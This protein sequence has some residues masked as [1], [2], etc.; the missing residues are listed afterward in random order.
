MDGLSAW[1]RTPLFVG[2]AIFLNA[3]N[4]RGEATG[5]AKCFFTPYSVNSTAR[6]F[7]TVCFFALFNKKAQY[8]CPQHSSPMEKDYKTVDP[9]NRA[10]KCFDI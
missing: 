8:G 1:V 7:K 9:F 5:K 10:G 4:S 6:R 3:Y 2:F